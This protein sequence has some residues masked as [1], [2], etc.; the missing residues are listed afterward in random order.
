M[1]FTQSELGKLTCM[2]KVCLNPLI[3]Y[4]KI[5]PEITNLLFSEANQMIASL[6]AQNER[7]PY[8]KRRKIPMVTKKSRNQE[9][10]EEIPKP[11][12]STLLGNINK[13]DI[14]LFIEKMQRFPKY[15][16]TKGMCSFE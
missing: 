2:N 6:N 12:S 7:K 9:T 15:F 1:T 14:E 10:N 8:F 3:G 16:A 4:I 13:T 11:N 5:T